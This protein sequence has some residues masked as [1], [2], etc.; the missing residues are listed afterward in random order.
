MMRYFLMFIA[1]FV[2][3]HTIAYP[4]FFCSVQGKPTK[5]MVDLD[6][7]TDLLTYSYGQDLRT[8]ELTLQI[9]REVIQRERDQNKKYFLKFSNGWHY[10]VFHQREPEQAGVEILNPEA[11]LEHVE[12][13]NLM[14]P[15]F[16]ELHTS[17]EAW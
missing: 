8:P 15:H 16:F 2:S 1:L 10:H 11:K 14:Q 9:P 13:C 17:F 5:L 12:W 7:K 6:E 4:I 3:Q